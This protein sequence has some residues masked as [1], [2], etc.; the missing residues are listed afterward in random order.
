MLEAVLLTIIIGGC[1]IGCILIGIA[2]YVLYPRC[3]RRNGDP[4]ERE[5]L[6][7]KRGGHNGKKEKWTYGDLDQAG[8]QR[9]NR[10]MAE[11]VA[12]TIVNGVVEED[13]G[14]TVLSSDALDTRHLGDDMLLVGSTVS[15][16]SSIRGSTTLS[17]RVSNLGSTRS[18]T[19]SSMTG[20]NND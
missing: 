11:V 15:T 2:V 14:A 16:T 19:N 7:Q 12:P 3:C 10:W 20:I 4:A 17:P 5:A 9:I 13:H 1:V 18:V 6:L 8:V